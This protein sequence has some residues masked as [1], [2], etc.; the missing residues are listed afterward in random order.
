MAKDPPKR[1]SRRS[2]ADRWRE[3]EDF[4]GPSLSGLGLAPVPFVPAL[5]E[6][7]HERTPGLALLA[8]RRLPWPCRPPSCAS[9]RNRRRRPSQQSPGPRRRCSASTPRPTTAA[10]PARVASTPMTRWRVDHERPGTDP[11]ELANLGSSSCSCFSSCSSNF[12]SC[13][14]SGIT[15]SSSLPT[16][17]HDVAIALNP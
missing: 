5:L 12:C 8:V 9:W 14:E 16:S 13:S 11:I 3:V 15:T 6:V 4:T 7:A 1:V 2:P 17:G 10:T